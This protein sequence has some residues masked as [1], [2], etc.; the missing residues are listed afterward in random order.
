M[1]SLTISPNVLSAPSY[2][3][4]CSDEGLQVTPGEDVPPVLSHHIQCSAAGSKKRH[5]QPEEPGELSGDVKLQ[6]W[7]LQLP[8]SGG[9]TPSTPGHGSCI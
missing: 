1:S 2:R 5:K 3:E 4:H 7:V 6:V 8:V 9:G